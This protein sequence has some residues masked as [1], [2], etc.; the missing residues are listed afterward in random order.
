LHLK[1][2][3]STS[4]LNFKCR[5]LQL[6]GFLLDQHLPN[7]WVGTIIDDKEVALVDDYHRRR[8][9]GSWHRTRLIHG[10]AYRPFDPFLD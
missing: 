2:W 9:V 10:V 5:L 3:E 1:Y 8:F 7:D 6:E 4:V